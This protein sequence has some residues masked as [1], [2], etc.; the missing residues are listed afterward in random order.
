[1]ETLFVRLFVW[2][3]VWYCFSPSKVGALDI[4]ANGAGPHHWSITFQV[5][6]EEGRKQLKK[7]AILFTLFSDGRLVKYSGSPW[8]RLSDRVVQDVWS[9]T[10]R[11]F[12]A[13]SLPHP[14]SSAKTPKGVRIRASLESGDLKISHKTPFVASIEALP[15]DLRGVLELI[16]DADPEIKNAYN[17]LR[18]Q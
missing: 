8:G 11:H 3:A 7:P 10:R 6:T 4:E 17:Q 18:V 15:K 1:M 9:A 5:E 14:T 12:D 13:L 2:A 16:A